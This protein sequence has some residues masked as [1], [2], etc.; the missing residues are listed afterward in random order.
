MMPLDRSSTT[1]AWI[2]SIAPG[3]AVFIS[4]A[5]LV[6]ARREANATAASAKSAR[7]SADEARRA[8]ELAER[9]EQRA[10]AASEAIRHRWEVVHYENEAYRLF[11]VGTDV[12]HDVTMTVNYPDEC[13]LDL[14]TDATIAPHDW[15]K[16]RISPS[17]SPDMPDF[18]LISWREHPEPLRIPLPLQS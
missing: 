16:F 3:I 2:A 15:H 18:L 11:N 5:A 13:L 12:A 8:N 10:L 17:L 4:I 6:Y 14:P 1:A 9:A 7:D